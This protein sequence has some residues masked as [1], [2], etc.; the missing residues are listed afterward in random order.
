MRRI[1]AVK[2]LHT[3]FSAVD[4]GGL[5]SFEPEDIEVETPVACGISQPVFIRCTVAVSR[6][7]AS[8]EFFASGLTM[9]SPLVERRTSAQVAAPLA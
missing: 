1:S 5:R 2:E 6:T 8:P 4:S 7:V 9:G 3:S